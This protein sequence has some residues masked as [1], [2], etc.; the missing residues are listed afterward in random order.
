MSSS[1]KGAASFFRFRQN[2][3][4]RGRERDRCHPCFFFP[5][6]NRKGGEKKGLA[7]LSQQQQKRYL[8][9]F[10]DINGGLH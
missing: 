2:A 3:R 5:V 4:V 7:Y 10:F 1:K 6:K 9:H 8:S